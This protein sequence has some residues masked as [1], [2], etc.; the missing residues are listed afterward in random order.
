MVAK[1]F[2]NRTVIRGRVAKVFYE[3][4]GKVTGHGTD[5]GFMNYGFDY[6]TSDDEPALL[7]RDEKERYPAQLYHEVATQIDLNGK[8]LLD[9]GSG[10]GGGA[11]YMHRYL[12]PSNTTGMD[13]AQSAVNFCNSVYEDIDGLCYV[14]GNATSIP[15]E[16]NSFDAVTN[17]ESSHCYKDIGAFFC[18]VFRVL[19]PGG[20]FLYTDYAAP[21]HPRR[22]QLQSAG[23]ELRAYRDITPNVA[24]GLV[25]DTERR[26]EVIDR[27]FPYGTRKL[28]KVWAGLDGGHIHTDFEEGRREYFI[29]H[30]VKP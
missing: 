4:V 2:G 17:V 29:I 24:R 12:G 3:F 10:R 30:A 27:L 5:V 22:T 13:L 16:S 9:I 1:L 8:A 19:K 11:S 28:A 6:D 23:F 18:E 14:Q 20:S 25:K 15:F 26:I 21:D 7:E